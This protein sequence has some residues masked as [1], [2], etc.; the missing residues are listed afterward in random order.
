MAKKTLYGNDLTLTH[1]QM[2][3]LRSADLLNLGINDALSWQILNAS[4]YRVNR[5]NVPYWGAFKWIASG[6]AVFFFY[7]GFTG[8][9]LWYF[10]GIIVP[11]VIADVISTRGIGPQTTT[12]CAAFR[13]FKHV[14][15]GILGYSIYLSFTRNWWWILLGL[16]VTSIVWQSNKK[17]G[18]ENLLDAAMIDSEFYERVQK[19][20]GWIYEIEES[21]ID[22]FSKH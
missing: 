10:V 22:K 6:I 15:L 18:S 21:E 20:D 1:A 13:F 16:F 2:V 4:G 19:L 11:P 3:E 12:A 7:L 8:H 5:F 17:G 9:W 14:S